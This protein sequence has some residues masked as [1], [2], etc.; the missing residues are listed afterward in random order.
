M[1]IS[2]IIVESWPLFV[3]DP[4]VAL[5][6]HLFTVLY[7]FPKVNTHFCFKIQCQN[8]PGSIFMVLML[9]RV[10]W[11]TGNPQ[12]SLLVGKKSGIWLIITEIREIVTENRD[13]IVCLAKKR[14][15]PFWRAM[16]QGNTEINIMNDVL[17]K[18]IG[19]FPAIPSVSTNKIA[20]YK[21][22]LQNH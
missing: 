1:S 18:L 17:S 22:A 15:P 12:I 11:K 6:Y 19:C 7:R 4:L 2:T 5:G 3:Y 21:C 8:F 10:P 9:P 13:K 20:S 14:V 16:N